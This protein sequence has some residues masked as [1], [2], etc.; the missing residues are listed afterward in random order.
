MA[1]LIHYDYEALDDA[2]ENMKRISDN[3]QV[4]CEGLTSDA[5]RLLQ[6]SA[7]K[8]ADGYDVKVKELNKLFEELNKMMADRTV[9]LQRRVDDMNLTDIKLGDGF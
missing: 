3:M 2:Y 9:E 5:L 8:Y 7:G 4:T 1:D 6:E